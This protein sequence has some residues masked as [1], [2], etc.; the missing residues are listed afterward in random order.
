MVRQFACC[1]FAA[2]M[3]VAI[4]EAPL[5]AASEKPAVAA[6]KSD[7][8]RPVWVDAKEGLSEEGYQRVIL[9]GPFST[10]AEC[11]RE[12][13]GKLEEAVDEYA[14]SYDAKLGPR[15]HMKA[16]TLRQEQPRLVRE[17]FSETVSTSV[18]PMR[19]THLRVIFDRKFNRW[20][21][22]QLAQIVVIQRVKVL[23][24]LGA[25]VLAVL[26]AAWLGLGRGDRPEEAGIGH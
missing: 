15:L 17:A 10:E 1:L 5:R 14:Q 3:L 9:V 4:G 24:V 16:A 19:Q 6:K 7:K 12:I 21:D 8:A 22:Q 18:G 11:D 2:M 20:L 13:P 23:A 26:A 25:L